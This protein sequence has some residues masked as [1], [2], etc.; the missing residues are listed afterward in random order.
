MALHVDFGFFSFMPVTLVKASS[1]KLT[2]S[3]AMMRIDDV[4]SAEAAEEGEVIWLVS[5]SMVALI[6]AASLSKSASTK[7]RLRISLPYL[8]ILVV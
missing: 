4:L 7:P 5:L 2:Q 1:A 3:V 8:M 6:C